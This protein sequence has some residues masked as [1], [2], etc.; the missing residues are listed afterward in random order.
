MWYKSP[1]NDGYEECLCTPDCLLTATW[2]RRGWVPSPEHPQP[3]TISQPTSHN[4]SSH[5]LLEI[6]DTNVTHTHVHARTQSLN[7][8]IS[9]GHLSYV[10]VSKYKSFP[11]FSS[12][13]FPALESTHIASLRAKGPSTCCL[14]TKAPLQ[15]SATASAHIFLWILPAT[16]RSQE[17]QPLPE[18]S[19][20][21]PM[22]ISSPKK[23][24]LPSLMGSKP[25]VEERPPWEN[26]RLWGWESKEY[27][28]FNTSLVQQHPTAS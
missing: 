20:Y 5:T 28:P 10:Y 22:I 24:T 16:S 14:L 7:F 11:F 21:P 13:T 9:S 25:A 18:T 8:K 6:Q 4:L 2:P 1:S 19:L 12:T 3:A 17:L 23:K 26:M 27:F 15:Q